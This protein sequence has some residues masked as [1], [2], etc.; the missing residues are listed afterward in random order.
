MEIDRAGLAAFLRRRRAAATQDVGLPRG[1][2]RRT[3][4]LRREEVA[5]LCHMS[6]DYSPGWSAGAARSRPSR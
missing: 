5:E 3:S 1:Q 6:T 2:R 4:G